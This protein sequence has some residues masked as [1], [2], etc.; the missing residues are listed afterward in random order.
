MVLSLTRVA[1]VLG[2]CFA[3][4]GTKGANL[5]ALGVVSWFHSISGTVKSPPCLLFDSPSKAP[6]LVPRVSAIFLSVVIFG[7]SD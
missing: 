4:Q 1:K 6:R 2:P 5:A 7:S 3:G